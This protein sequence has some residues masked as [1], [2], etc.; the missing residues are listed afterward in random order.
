[1]ELEVDTPGLD[2]LPFLEAVFFSRNAI[3]MRR[4]TGDR[5]GFTESKRV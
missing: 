3:G 4:I 1:M 2:D 5:C